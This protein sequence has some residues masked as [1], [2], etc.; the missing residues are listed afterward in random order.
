MQ[1]FGDDRVAVRNG[2]AVGRFR[3]ACVPHTDEACFFQATPAE[4]R[5]KPNSRMD[6]P[7][8]FP[9]SPDLAHAHGA[10]QACDRLIETSHRTFLTRITALT[11]G[12]SGQ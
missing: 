6:I 4:A 10:D 3:N 2:A 11:C 7:G 1:R 12:A 9:V 8:G 5:E